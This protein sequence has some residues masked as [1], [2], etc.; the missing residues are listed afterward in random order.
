[1]TASR[2]PSMS[3]TGAFREALLAGQSFTRTEACSRFGFNGGTFRWA[4]KAMLESGVPL[5][6]EIVP[7]QRGN[8]ARRWRVARAGRPRSIRS[9]TPTS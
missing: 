8:A 4:I 7:G 6:Y 2:S 9:R 5:E 1:M 3:A